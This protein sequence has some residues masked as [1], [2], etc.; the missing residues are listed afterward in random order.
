MPAARQATS[1]HRRLLIAGGIGLAAFL[2]LTGVVL[3]AAFR[4]SARAAVQ[5]RLQ[6][7]VYALLAAAELADD[8]TLMIPAG[9]PEE[10]LSRPGSGL[11]A[12]VFGTDFKWL[13]DSALGVDLPWERGL[14]PG[15]SRFSG[16]LASDAGTVFRLGQ[17]V[18]WETDASGS[19]RFTFDVMESTAVFHEQVDRF[20]R[21]LWIWLGAAAL[22]LLGLQYA[23]QRW[24]LKPLRAVSAELEEVEAG[25]QEALHGRY[26]AEL[27]AFRDHLNAFIQAERE[28]L[29]RYRNTLADLAHSL[30]TPLAVLR[31]G[32]SGGGP[33][34]EDLPRLRGQVDRMDELVAYRLKRAAHAGGRTLG[35]GTRVA[36]VAEQV[37][38]ALEKV[39]AGRGL[40]CELALDP[41][42]EFPGEEGDLY[43]L[44]G[45]LADNAFKWARGRVRVTARAVPAD[46][47]HGLELAVEDDGPGMPPG[48]FDELVR[49][50]ARGDER[51]PGQGLGLAMVDDIVRAYGGK[52]SSETGALGGAR[53]VVRFPG[54]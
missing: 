7:Q 29:K 54:R 47:R 39:H 9:L 32:L 14:D 2:G 6:G 36:P 48:K 45:N 18:A 33:S 26:P 20:R 12:G 13:S 51:K 43:E 50:G 19:V 44:L 27:A 17:G 34:S 37:T 24:T 10:R 11:Y 41:E 3:D 35:A 21:T 25:R 23:L 30:K 42:A 8:G 31:G 40:R 38:S 4:D 22:V 16:P 52:L 5:D 46:R 15:E 49:R 1:L 28:H 53:V